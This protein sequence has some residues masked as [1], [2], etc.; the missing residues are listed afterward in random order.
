[1]GVTDTPWGT[2]VLPAIA[3]PPAREFHWVK[4]TA[5]KILPPS[6]LDNPV[7]SEFDGVGLLGTP[8]GSIKRGIPDSMIPEKE[9]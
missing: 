1:M 4:K 2:V 9:K 8:G 5:G 7:P 6:Q 3:R